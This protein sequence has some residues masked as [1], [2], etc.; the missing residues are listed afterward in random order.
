[1]IK[2]LHKEQV[3]LNIVN[4]FDDFDYH[5]HLCFVLEPLAMDLEKAI[6]G[7]TQGVKGKSLGIAT[8]KRF[9]RHIFRA[10]R[11]MRKLGYIHGDLKPA[12]ILID[13]KNTVLKLCDFG[14]ASVFQPSKPFLDVHLGSM[15][16]RPPEIIMAAPCN[17]G[18]DVWQAA[19]VLFECFT[20]SVMFPGKHDLDQLYLHQRVKG[21][22]PSKMIK[23]SSEMLKEQHKHPYFD[24]EQRFL[25]T[26]T[27]KSSGKT[28]VK[29]TFFGDK[30]EVDLRGMVITPEIS[31]NWTEAETA[32]AKHFVDLLQATLHLNPETRMSAELAMKH[33]FVVADPTTAAP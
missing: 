7:V 24:Q 30:V 5:N 6:F 27:D 2:E 22:F 32:L 28:H 18:V 17:F 11:H 31:Q 3:Q 12:N 1:V 10:L 25:R 21:R 8:T 13:G 15:W 16:Y 9:S 20:G 14:Q 26:V 4:L 23:K 29:A 19:C 33:K